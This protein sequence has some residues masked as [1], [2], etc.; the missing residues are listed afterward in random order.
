MRGKANPLSKNE[1][2]VS[3]VE[4]G[5]GSLR[6]P[7]LVKLA[8]LFAVPLEYLVGLSDNDGWARVGG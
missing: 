3:N 5:S 1:A 4:R 2:R 6:T 7:E 8:Q